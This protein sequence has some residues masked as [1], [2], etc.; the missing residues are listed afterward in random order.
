MVTMTSIGWKSSS[1]AK[2][3]RTDPVWTEHLAVS[4]SS[5]EMNSRVWLSA[6][7]GKPKPGA[8]QERCYATVLASSGN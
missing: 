1:R 8:Q 4:I 7:G 5:G 3:N 2:R 6:S